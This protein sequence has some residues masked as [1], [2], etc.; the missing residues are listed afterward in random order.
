MCGCRMHGPGRTRPRRRRRHARAEP[1]MGRLAQELV[2]LWEFWLLPLA[3]ALLPYRAG[4]ALARWC[5]SA[6]P[7]YD[8]RA[9]AG[10]AHYRAARPRGDP[11][12]WLTEFRFTQL[13]DHADLFWA[14]TRSERFLLSRLDAP[15]RPGEP[16]LM[17][18]GMHF[19]Q[20]L[21]L[22][23]WLR[24]CGMPA[25]FLSVRFDASA[26]ESRLRLPLRAAADARGRKAGRR[27]G[28]LHGRR[29]GRNRR[30]AVAAGAGLWP[31]R[32]AHRH[33]VG[34]QRDALR[35]G[36]V[37][38]VRDWSTPRVR[39]A[40]TCCCSPRTAR[41]TGV[42]ASLRSASRLPTSTTSRRGSARASTRRPGLG[43]SGI[44]CR[45]SP[46]RTSKRRRC[47]DLPAH[48]RSRERRFAGAAFALDPNWL[49]RAGAWGRRRVFHRVAEAAGRHRRRGRH[50]S[51]G[52]SRC[53][54]VRAAR[55][56]RRPRRRRLG[57]ATRRRRAA[58]RATT[59]SSA[60]MCS[61][62]CTTALDCSR[63]CG[64]C[65]RLAANCCCRFPTSRM[66][67][68]SRA[69][70]TIVSNTA[71]RVCSI[72]RTCAF[73]HGVRSLRC[74]A[75]RLPDPRVG[76]H[77]A[78]ALRD[79]V[80]HAR[81]SACPGAA[82]SAGPGTRHYAYQWLVRATPG[83]MDTIP[84]P[85]ARDVAERVPVRLTVRADARSADARLASAWIS[86]PPTAMPPRSNGA[87][88][89]ARPCCESFFPIASASSPSMS[90]RCSP[91]SARSG[92]AAHTGAILD[93]GVEA[94]RL[95]ATPM[96]W[97][98]P[99]HGSSRRCPPISA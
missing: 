36:R 18:I 25:R 22:L 15:P 62:I 50:R 93:A 41:S 14:L 24:A 70:S 11:R 64:R 30:D 89:P 91:A 63:G 72:R 48:V 37:L 57:S 39:Q 74:C 21:W 77:R 58:R 29:K 2:C 51:R 44:S 23:R 20:G 45:T 42:G 43:T 68:S 76:R 40:R 59:S 17:V 71:A 27:A 9:R 8:E 5:A 19:G 6:L 1:P 32:R 69:C 67:R 90:S 66:R 97:F 79:R 84:M 60:P 55:R 34:A 33:A 73:I 12:R 46:H 94:V 95:E 78:D 31:D 56:R 96:R 92:A 98:V 38:A 53:R 82:W 75:S 7:L 61:S 3:V 49:E 10:L 4:I 35:R 88:R 54:N 47:R 26:F 86:F 52:R 16:P 99:T 87:S 81:R 28:D 83:E 80:S 85:P 13:I 65:S